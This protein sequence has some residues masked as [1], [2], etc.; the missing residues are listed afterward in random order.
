MFGLTPLGVVHTLISLVAL[1]SGLMALVTYRFIST[2]NGLGMT[3]VVTTALTAATGLGIYQHGGF[4]APHGLSILTLL[5]L[6]AGVAAGATQ[7]FGGRSR[8]V[9]AVAYSSTFLFH[10]IPAFTESLTR[11]PL[12]AP[13]FASAEAPALKA[14]YGVLLV[15]FVVG[16][17]VQ[18]RWLRARAA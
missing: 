7:A 3:Y 6:A 16:L 15:L 2:T 10:A 9:E 8:Y 13:L 1:A 12:G 14:I 18:L 4:G 11:L 5:A 17:V